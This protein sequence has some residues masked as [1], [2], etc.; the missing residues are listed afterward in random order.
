MKTYRCL[1]CD[2]LFESE[3]GILC[4]ECGFIAP[5]NPYD[6]R[7]AL[8]SE[9]EKLLDELKFHQDALSLYNFYHM[10]FLIN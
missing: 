7:D 6:R 1:R 9:T 3:K 5:E 8:I 10:W 4:P 2:K